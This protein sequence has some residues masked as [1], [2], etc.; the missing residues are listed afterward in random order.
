MRRR[1]GGSRVPCGPAGRGFQRDRQFRPLLRPCSCAGGDPAGTGAGADRI[2]AVRGLA[3]DARPGPGALSQPLLPG[4]PAARLGTAQF[5]VA[6]AWG[7]MAHGVPPGYAGSAVARGHARQRAPTKVG[8]Y[9]RRASPERRW[10]RRLT[11]A[12]AS[13]DTVAAF[14]PWRDFRPSVAR[15]RRGH[16]RDVGRPVGG[17][18]TDQGKQRAMRR[19]PQPDCTSAG[20]W[21]NATIAQAGTST[22]ASCTESAVTRVCWQRP[23]AT[24]VARMP[25]RRNDLP[26]SGINDQDGLAL[27]RGGLSWPGS[28]CC[29]PACWKSSGPCP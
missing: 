11:S 26:T 9:Q 7:R 24:G 2:G 6:P 17:R 8:I 15:G 5:A 13:I 10:P 3:A 16:H 4:W 25:A 29:S 19:R 18:F 12:P 28:I 22:P 23:G 21:Q 1:C 27:P 20:R 14:R